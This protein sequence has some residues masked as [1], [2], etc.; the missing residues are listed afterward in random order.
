VR[1]TIL[2]FGVILPLLA[3]R[4]FAQADANFPDT[5][6]FVVGDIKIFGN[7]ITK[8]YVILDELPFTVGDTI[9]T[10]DLSYA[11][12]R[13]YSL[14]LFNFVD[15][16]TNYKNPRRVIILVKEAWYIFPVPF[17]IF[18][19]NSIKYSNYGMDVLWKNFRGRN[20]TIMATLSFGFDPNFSGSYFNPN[21]IGR[22]VRLSL[23]AGT[24]SFS[25][26]SVAFEETV[27][28]ENFSMR[29]YY[30][31]VGLGYR[32]DYHGKADFF[33]SYR[34]FSLD[35]P[36]ASDYFA[37]RKD[38][39]SSVIFSLNIV[40][41]TRNLTM[42]ASAGFYFSLTA[43]ITLFPGINNN[44]ET[45]E[46]KY[47]MNVLFDFRKYTELFD[48]AI[49]RTRLKAMA[50][51]F[52]TYIP[53]YDKAYFGYTT[54]IRGHA[55]DISEGDRYFLA[56]FELA[57]PFVNDFRYSLDLPL[58]PNGLTATRFGAQIL[59][60]FDA[61]KVSNS[62]IVGEKIPY[63]YGVGLNLLL[64]PYN[65]F[66]FAFAGNERGEWEFLFETGFSF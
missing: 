38:K 65:E 5:T 28:K 64:L 22:N 48:F 50:F 51:P 33:V 58:I 66:R 20:E 60:F 53:Y 6:K 9:S 29:S 3:S 55:Y 36:Y 42:N 8:D 49:L 30:G 19:K 57:I 12:E 2:L 37:S 52:S 35:K 11:K 14:K 21:F 24:V 32:F 23:A 7:E 41:D 4:G 44:A 16:V 56:N 40:R 63:G 25:N 54:Y 62:F 45:D 61:G 18:R 34:T 17:I 15:V 43:G 59:L 39:E 27:A 13:V 1:R 26:K 31:T 47:N 46:L 10:A